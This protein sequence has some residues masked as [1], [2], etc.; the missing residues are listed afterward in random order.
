MFKNVGKNDV[1]PSFENSQQQ[2]RGNHTD[3]M[4][5]GPKSF[6]P[7]RSSF[8]SAA[9]DRS[10]FDPLLPKTNHSSNPGPN[11]PPLDDEHQVADKSTFL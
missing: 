6:E 9:P 4:L 2:R 7:P 11:P 3:G 5:F 8:D 1:N 10:R